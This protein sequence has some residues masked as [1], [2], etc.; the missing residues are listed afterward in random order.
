[1]SGIANFRGQTLSILYR[2]TRWYIRRLR[3]CP[4]ASPLIATFQLT[5]RCNLRCVMCNI[6]NNPET[7]TM[8]LELFKS[9]VR[10][11]G[12]LGCCYAS[13][14]GGEVLT[15]KDFPEYLAAAKRHIPSV[16]MVTN[17]ILLDEAGASKIGRC[18]VDSVS[19]SL[20]GMEKTHEETRRLPGSF[21]KTV[22]AIELLKR[23]SPS[24]KIV[25]NT[26][27]A[28]WN[29][30]ELY[31]LV[32]FVEGLGVLHKFQPL[33][34]HPRFEGQRGSYPDTG[35]MG[36][37]EKEI[38]DLIRFLMRR[39]NVANSRY[40]LSSIPRYVL[41][42]TEGGVFDDRCTLPAFFCEFRENG[43]LYPCLGGTSWR[44]GFDVSRGLKEIFESWEYS[45]LADSLR[46]CRACRNSFS[47]CY[48]EPRV[49]FPLGNLLKY[50]FSKAGPLN[51]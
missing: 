9:I 1:M 15:I 23:F 17:G 21:R 51:G 11:L 7:N 38:K 3:A 31:E 43:L 28:P 19:V 41:K 35:N 32:E 49:S 8:P 46:S 29:V 34:P 24:S 36:F 18:G 10:E 6:P 40:F 30:K 26:V 39:K 42:R 45:T 44:D 16:N 25:V 37:D 12:A 48:I 33:N 13:L 22:N 5:N 27:I 20:D 2:V 14:S 4:S 50:R 47:V